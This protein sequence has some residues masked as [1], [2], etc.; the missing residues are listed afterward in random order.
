VSETERI[1]RAYQELAAR[2][3]ARWDQANPGNR[4][5]LAERRR[6]TRRVLDH[7]GWLP[8]GDRRIL[9][10]GSG[11]G[12]ELAWLQELGAAPS[13]LC[14]VDLLPDRVAQARTAYPG[15]EFRQGNAERLDFPDSSFD[16]V[17]ALTVFSSIFDESMARNVAGEIVRVLKP[18]GG[19]FWYDVRYDSPSNRNVHAVT[20]SRVRDLF[21]GL[22][23]ELQSITLAPPLARRLGPLTRFAYPALAPIPPLRSHLIGLLMKRA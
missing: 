19:L 5:I 23:G 21:G 16:L 18:R 8:L 1:A 6:V 13:R 2:G 20:R 22:T 10:V 14:G 4:A 15:I 12:S 11:G 3:G 17:L 9:E 7:A